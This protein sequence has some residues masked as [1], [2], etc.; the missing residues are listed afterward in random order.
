M[1]RRPPESTRTDTLFPYT[2]LFR[3]PGRTAALG[4]GCDSHRRD[5][6]KA[7]TREAGG[8]EGGEKARG[9]TQDG[10]DVEA[11]GGEKDSRAQKKS[12]SQKKTGRSVSAL[13][14]C[15]EMTAD[16][17]QTAGV[18]RSEERRVGKECDSTGNSRG[19]LKH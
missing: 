1:I 19:S 2:T 9:E 6:E 10:K 3:A 7:E 13:F 4:H 8:G 12:R 15:R 16:Q 5:D 14:P 17:S 18:D 11:E